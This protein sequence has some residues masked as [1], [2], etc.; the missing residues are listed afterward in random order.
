MLKIHVIVILPSL[1][2]GVVFC[3]VHKLKRGRAGL[4]LSEGANYLVLHEKV[5]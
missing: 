3:F 4:N 5:S 2:D 1:F